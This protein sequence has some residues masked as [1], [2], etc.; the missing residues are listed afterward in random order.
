MRGNLQQKAQKK[1]ARHAIFTL[2]R[3]G[4]WERK[5]AYFP[6]CRAMVMRATTRSP[7][8]LVMVSPQGGP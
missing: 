6:V 3:G 1:P 8:P 5:A 4:R 2:R 7:S